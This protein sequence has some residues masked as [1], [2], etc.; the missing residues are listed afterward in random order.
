MG[1]A[2]GATAG[3]A[4]GV[5]GAG[6][7]GGAGGGLMV[8]PAEPAAGL[9]TVARDVDAPLRSYVAGLDVEQADRVSRGFELFRVEWLPGASQQNPSIDGLGPLFN[10]SS[11][12]A[13]HPPA[14]RAGDFATLLRMQAT[15]DGL[16][17]ADPVYG[18]QL[19]TASVAAATLPPE[20]AL[21]ISLDCPAS[22]PWGRCV[23]TAALS[24]LGYGPMH[25]GLRTGLRTAPA[26]LGAGLLARV[27]EAAVLAGQDPLDLDADGVRGV[28]QIHG[29][30]S[31]GRFGWKADQTSLGAQTAAALS[32][33]MGLTSSVLPG[34]PC[35]TA[36]TAC[37]G[38]PSGGSPEVLDVDLARI[39][40]F[41]EALGVPERDRSDLEAETLGYTR[42]V[43]VGCAAC[44]R[45]SFV[46][47]PDPAWPQLSEQLIHPWT[48]L[49]LHDLGPEL[50]DGIV[51][52]LATGAHFRTPPLWGVGILAATPHA[53][54]L[55]DGRAR[56]IREAVLWHGGEA[57]GAR[58]AFLALSAEEQSALL[59]FV[60]SL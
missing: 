20:A 50:A 42:F 4:T 39:V 2:G 46:T 22:D 45:Q 29:E 3:G 33:D 27:P 43:E 35:T 53:R 11:C 16:P 38:L 48:D 58:A 60:G 10:A 41:Q 44:H 30:G 47:A 15:I 40:A 24:S 49:L 51:V 36:Q 18:G 8:A 52:G 1:G 19:Q 6:G 17:A 9:A 32:N 7:A 54:L 13:C 14:S 57:E 12:A 37:A 21:T 55:H 23:T 26:L 5:G 56:T 34:S 59:R 31:L 25:A 28:A